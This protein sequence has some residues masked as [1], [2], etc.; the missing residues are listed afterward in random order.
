MAQ[1]CQF[2]SRRKAARALE[3]LWRGKSVCPLQLLGNTS[4]YF[5]THFSI[6]L[7]RCLTFQ[8]TPGPRDV[9][10]ER[11]RPS[12][13]LTLP[14]GWRKFSWSPSLHTKGSDTQD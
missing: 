14:Q 8:E 2:H 4:R 7:H 11:R 13:C 10:P 3:F 9:Q 6:I 12:D 5:D 1:R